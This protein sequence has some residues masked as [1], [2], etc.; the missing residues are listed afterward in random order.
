MNK[1][2]KCEASYENGM[3]R[4]NPDANKTMSAKYSCIDYSQIS[5]QIQVY[6]CYIP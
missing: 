4:N 6:K 5:A 3:M 1:T 2:K